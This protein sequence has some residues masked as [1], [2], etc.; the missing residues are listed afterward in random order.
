MYKLFLLV[1]VIS[2]SVY[3]LLKYL[4]KVKIK[5]Q[6]NYSTKICEQDKIK[7]A[8]S[9]KEIEKNKTNKKISN[10]SEININPKITNSNLNSRKRLKTKEILKSNYNVG[11][12]VYHKRFGEGIIKSIDKNKRFIIIDF[13]DY[14]IKK[15]EIKICEKNKLLSFKKQTVIDKNNK[16]KDN[17]NIKYKKDINIKKQI[18]TKIINKPN[19]ENKKEKY[20]IEKKIGEKIFHEYFGFGCLT[21]VDEKYVT[22]RFDDFE[23]KIFSINIFQKRDLIRFVDVNESF[24]KTPIKIKKEAKVSSSTNSKYNREKWDHS[25]QIDY[26]WIDKIGKLAKEE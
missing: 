14:G 2:F 12:I 22:I 11:S 18:N 19:I 20:K 17:E 9:V 21:S 8:K 15:L 6:D 10:I 5:K 23:T 24:N 26:N 25:Y 3:Y 13:H 4:K 1:L 7:V 16:C